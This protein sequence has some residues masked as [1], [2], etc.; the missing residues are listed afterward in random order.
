MSPAGPRKFHVKLGAVG[1]KSLL[2]KGFCGHA[3]PQ[4][5]GFMET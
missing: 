4:M 2:S 5:Q 3:A 1:A